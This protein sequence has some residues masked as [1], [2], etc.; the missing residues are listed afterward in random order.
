MQL[1]L[2]TSCL[3]IRQVF[4]HSIIHHHALAVKKIA[5]A[6]KTLLYDYESYKLYDIKSIKFKNFHCTLGWSRK[7]LERQSIGLCCI[8]KYWIYCWSPL[9]SLIM[10]IYS[11]MA[12]ETVIPCWNFTRINKI[13]ASLEHVTVTFLSTCSKIGLLLWKIEFWRTCI[14]EESQSGFPT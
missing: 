7:W 9:W 3:V 1:W 6:L 14:E 10:F 12:L 5:S 4:C 8:Q 13:N 2:S 11:C